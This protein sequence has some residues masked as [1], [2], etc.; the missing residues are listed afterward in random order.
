MFVHT[1]VQHW[2]SIVLLNIHSLYSI[3][4]VFCSFFL[5]VFW[6]IRT[7]FQWQI[8]FCHK[9][10]YVN[11]THTNSN[12][13]KMITIFFIRLKKKCLTLIGTKSRI[14]KNKFLF[15]RGGKTINDNMQGTVDYM[16]IGYLRYL[17]RYF[18]AWL[19]SSLLSFHSFFFLLFFADV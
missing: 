13:D 5:S 10:S 18:I 17:Q 3:F 15:P 11:G 4:F 9:K 19:E 7:V 6:L 14:K 8:F 2:C 12:K 1:Y 16:T